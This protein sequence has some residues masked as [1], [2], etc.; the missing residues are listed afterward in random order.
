ML[1]VIALDDSKENDSKSETITRDYRMSPDK[2]RGRPNIIRL[3]LKITEYH[4]RS[5]N[6]LTLSSTVPFAA[7][8]SDN[9]C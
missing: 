1:M 2:S 3:L 7:A 9:A 5:Q 6:I 8:I 4:R